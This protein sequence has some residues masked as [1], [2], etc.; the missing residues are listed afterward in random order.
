[1]ITGRQIRAARSLLDW[2]ATTLAEKAG[3]TRETV[4]RIETDTVQ[5]QERSMAKIAKTFRENGVEF[6]DFEGVRRR[7]DN[8]HVYSGREGLIALMED[9]YT[10]CQLGIAGDI[11]MSGISEDDFQ[12]YLGEY[13]QEYLKKMSALPPIHMRHLIAEDDYNVVSSA[14]SQY[15]WVA[16]SQFKAVP[17]YVYAD[18]LA[19]ILFSAVPAPKI[20]VIHSAEVAEAYRSQ[21]EGMWHS[22]REIPE[23]KVS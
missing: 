3:L 19:I 1:V 15:R 6:L 8:I 18:K 16:R 7:P 22:A 9:V 20:F 13:D 4:S 17:F 2:D 11:V 10:A 5:A 14:Y 23:R 12:K 21:F